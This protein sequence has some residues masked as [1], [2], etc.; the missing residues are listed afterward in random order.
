MP[1]YLSPSVLMVDEYA[2][3]PYDRESVTVLFILVSARNERSSITLAST[4]VL[5]EWGELLT[6]RS[7]PRP[8]WTARCVS[9]TWKTSAVRAAGPRRYDWLGRSPPI[10]CSP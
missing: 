4:K 8:Y 9:A 1:V 7:S 6:T 10:S 3:W 5:G 2:I